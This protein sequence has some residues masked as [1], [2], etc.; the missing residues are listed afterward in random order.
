MKPPRRLTND[1]AF[2]VPTA[3]TGDSKAVLFYRDSGPNIFKQGISQVTS[4]PV[5]TGPQDVSTPR[6][7]A[8]G[9]L[10][11][12]VESRRTLATPAPPD[13][14]MRI[15]TSGGVP[16]FVLETR[17]WVD[18][19]CARAPANLCV[20]FETSQDRK[21]LMITAFDPMKGRGKLL[22]TIEEEAMHSYD[23]LALS[24]DGSTVAVSRSAEPEINIH[25]LSLTGRYDREIKVKSWSNIS[26]M[27]WSNDGNGFY[28][29]AVSPQGSTLLYVD[30]NGNARVLWQYKGLNGQIWGVPSPDGRYLAI[31]GT[32]TNS[33]VW[34][35]EGF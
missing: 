15:P 5:Y 1:E 35:V 22:R 2:D 29:G 7:S 25:L 31:M 32:V 17:N 9:A 6:L 11:L 14:L 27:D 19:V 4:E 10:I 3:W 30:L 8:D 26:G 16:Q 34:M 23:H 20:I 33:N 13:R 21:Q 18:F 28:C 12:F 24:P